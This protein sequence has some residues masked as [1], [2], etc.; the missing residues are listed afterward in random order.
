MP[1]AQEALEE[2]EKV[3]WIPANGKNRIRGAVETRPDWCISRQRTW[4]IPLPVFYGEGGSRCSAKEV[5]LRL[6][7]PGGKGRRRHLVRR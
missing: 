2:I 1:S 7:R 4:G 3:N 5:V 6:C